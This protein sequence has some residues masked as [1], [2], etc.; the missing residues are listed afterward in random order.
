MRRSLLAAALS[1]VV[2]AGA[3]SPARA[4]DLSLGLQ[5][6]LFRPDSNLGDV[7]SAPFVSPLVDVQ[8]G[9]L[10]FTLRY[11]YAQYDTTFAEETRSSLET[12]TNGLVEGVAFDSIVDGDSERHDVDVALRFR[13]D[14]WSE[15]PLSFTA[16]AGL[17][18]ELQSTEGDIRTDVTLEGVTPGAE[19]ILGDVLPVDGVAGIRIDYSIMALPIGLGLSY[20][21]GDTGLSPF[22][23]ATL[24]PFARV[25]FSEFRESGVLG[26]TGIVSDSLSSAREGQ[27]GFGGF[28]VE[29]GL[30]GSLHGA[31]EIPASFTLSY[32]L[33]R[34][35][36]GS[37]EDELQQFTLGLFWH[38][39]GAL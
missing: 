27:D 5:G 1:L 32:R 30:A 29:A 24:F 20:R 38:L 39:P 33:Q 37:F 31:L 15:L 28:A 23:V 25:D 2:G 16:F 22:L 18:Y 14:P 4:A 9:P 11:I 13:T 10:G 26:N 36:P 35:G 6:G 19:E 7:T 21:V 8:S 34:L 3:P 12:L 17:R